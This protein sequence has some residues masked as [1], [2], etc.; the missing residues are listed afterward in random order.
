M[1]N[2]G[3]L[4]LAGVVLLFVLSGPRKCLRCG[5]QRGSSNCRMSHGP[6]ARNPRTRMWTRPEWERY[7]ATGET[8]EW[9]PGDH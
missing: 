2:V 3:W 7:Q 1:S 9:D 8:P 5:W 6:D 4:I